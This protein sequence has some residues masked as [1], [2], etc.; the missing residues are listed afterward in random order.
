MTDQ[1]RSRLL[2]LRDETAQRI[3]L[4]DAELHAVLVDRSDGSADDEHDPEGVP[5]SAEWSML[6]SV[7][8]DAARTLEEVDDALARH[9]AGTYGVCVGCGT[10]IPPERLE[11]RPT[12]V[13]CVGCAERAGR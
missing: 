12:A 7:R 4:L 13:L 2:A 10:E 11:A 3:A 1:P 5:L 9:D 6:A 8:R